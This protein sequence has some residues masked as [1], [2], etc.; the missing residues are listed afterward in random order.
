M[1]AS[2]CRAYQES[3][4]RYKRDLPPTYTETV[5]KAA[6]LKGLQV[7]KLLARG[8]ASKILE[9]NLKQARSPYFAGLTLRI[10]YFLGASSPRVS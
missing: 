8:P 2:V 5:H 4:A 6:L 10:F 9:E 1:D 7:F 3:L